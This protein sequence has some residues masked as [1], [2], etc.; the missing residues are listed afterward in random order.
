MSCV[1]PYGSAASLALDISSEALVAHCAAPVGEALG[2][3]AL[4]VTRALAEPLE[5][6]ALSRATVPGDRIVLAVENELPQTAEMVAAV[7]RYFVETGTAPEALTVLRPESAVS[8]TDGDPRRLLPADWRQKVA[9]E[10]H[11]S[12][13]VGR[14][15]LLGSTRNGEGVYLNRALLDADLVVPIGCLRCE[16]T[17][18]FHGRH[19]G[20]FPMFSNTKTLGR[21]LKPH[22]PDHRREHEARARREIDEVGWM[23]GAMCTVQVVPGA[24]EALLA[25]LAGEVRRVFE[26]GQD[27]CQAAWNYIAPRRA[28]L[29]V[30]AISGG[31]GQQTWDNV[32]RALSAA[33]R[34]TADGGAV[35]LCTELAT[36]P[37]PA[38]CSLAQA[39]DL[40][41][42]E[43]QIRRASPPDAMAAVELARVLDQAKVYLLSRLDESIVA[44]LGL[45][46]VSSGDEVARL[47]R[48]HA[49]CIVLANAQHA[50]VIPT[51][52]S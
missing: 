41:D 52:D 42:A 47:T 8:D 46:P 20:L 36:E 11:D 39:E 40:A 5:F 14:L 12:S 3:V 38:I 4:A 49:S 30:A 22:S 16:P 7:A 10:V 35:V 32:A 17:L 9:Y 26:L 15:G 44:D 29:V 27:Q 13:A 2:D 21:F 18:G 48:R 24:G 50:R 19:A 6:P 23:L 51:E 33:S 28:S 37:G 25:V 34:I 31:P 1:L 45:A 43:R